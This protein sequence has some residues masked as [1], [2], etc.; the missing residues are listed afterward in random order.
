LYRY[1]QS[2]PSSV[3][4]PYLINGL[5]PDSAFSIIAGKPKHGES[6]LAR[7]EAVCVAKGTSA[8]NSD[9]GTT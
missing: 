1:R 3:P 4:F 9:Q 2:L 7:Y 8:N 5:L 6:S